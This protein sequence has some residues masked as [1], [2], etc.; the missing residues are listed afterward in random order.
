[1]K[2]SLIIILLAFFFAPGIKA[3]SLSDVTFNA[4]V[5]AYYA[6]NIDTADAVRQFAS[7]SPYNDEFRINIAQIGAKY[8][9]SKVHAAITLHYGDIP[10]VNWPASQQ[11]IQEA[12]AGVSPAKNLWIDAGYFLTHIG[13]EGLLPRNNYLTSQSLG[14]YFESFFQSGVRVN[15]DFSPKVYGAFYALNGNN[16]FVDNNK[17]KSF[18][19]TLGVKPVTNLELIYN[20]LLGNEQPGDLKSKLRLYNNL[21]VKY[22]ASEKTDLLVGFDFATQEDSKLTDSLASASAF[23]GLLTVRYKPAERFSLTLRGEFFNDKDAIISPLITNQDS[24]V[25]G[26]KAYGVTLG[27]EYKPLQ[28]AYVRIE[29]RVISAA[30][31]QKIFS[32]NENVNFESI[33]NMGCEF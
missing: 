21:V 10:S 30:N 25:S 26:L 1:M 24:T 16:V 5:D 17:N 9:T 20:N 19:I 2:K 8:T 4:Y 14:T 15:Y 11:F 18:G 6:Y 12:Y 3:Q 31:E 28:N 7:I 33:L 22:T 13:A 29:G 23:S 32:G 27:F